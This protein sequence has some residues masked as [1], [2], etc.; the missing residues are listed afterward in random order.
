LI[1]IQTQRAFEYIVNSNPI[2]IVK[3]TPNAELRKLLRGEL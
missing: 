1:R 3:Y 2:R